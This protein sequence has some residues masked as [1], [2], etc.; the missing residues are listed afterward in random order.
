MCAHTIG[1]K[2]SDICQGGG[3]VGASC[4]GMIRTAAEGCL[5]F[6]SHYKDFLTEILA[7]VAML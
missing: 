4:E 5:S 1:V 7:I 6:V 3:A 2:V